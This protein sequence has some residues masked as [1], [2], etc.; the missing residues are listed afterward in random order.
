MKLSLQT[1]LVL[2]LEMNNPSTVFIFL[3]V[4]SQ[5]ALIGAGGSVI[6]LGSDIAGSG[7][8]PPFYCGICGHKPTPSK[9]YL[10]LPTGFHHTQSLS[11]IGV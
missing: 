8:L 7:R 2:Y 3:N 10:S 9:S 11:K 6:G 5:A 4:L 1:V